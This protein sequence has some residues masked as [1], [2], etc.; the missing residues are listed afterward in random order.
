MFFQSQLNRRDNMY[1]KKL[2]RDIYYDR[3]LY[4]MLLP[5]LCYFLIFHYLPMYGVTIAFRDYNIVRGFSNAPWVGLDVF[6]KL[7][8]RSAFIHALENNI[9]ISLMKIIIGFPLPIL[10][11]LLI[12]ETRSR[13]YKRFVQSAVILPSFISWFVIYGI[14]VA[15][16]NVT[17][18]II[19]T[20]TR[21]INSI[22]GT[23]FPIVNY[24]T[25][26]S[27]VDAYIMITYVWKGIGMGTVVYLAVMVS[28]DSQ[29]YEAAMIDGAGRLRQIWHITLSSL[30]P[31]IIT[32]LIFRVGE[33][34][35]AGF[36]QIFALSNSLIQSKIDIIDTYVY[37][38]GLEEAKFS[39]A[40]AA[41]L[42]K[43]F[44]GLIL[45]I[46]T[47]YLAKHIDPE[48]AIM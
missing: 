2:V 34:M 1:L 33:I 8:S 26:K 32:L 11:S 3:W 31:T 16:C 7:F 41:G 39:L 21:S 46:G 18:G 22:F 19:P 9:R 23:S 43:S 42:F 17:D 37:R 15:L 47:N 29:L 6:E 4:I 12:H 35:N 27:T 25:N 13:R 36:D 48:S 30:R 10:L 24:M 28:I 5:G 14:L 44:I 20:L 45:V 38:I 40:T